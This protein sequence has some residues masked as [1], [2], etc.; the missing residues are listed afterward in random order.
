MSNNYKDAFD[1]F[2]RQEIN[3]TPIAIDTA[4]WMELNNALDFYYKEKVTTTWIGTLRMNWKMI[5]TV[6][7]IIF[8]S[9][10]L[11]VSLVSKRPK[12]V[13][14]KLKQENSFVP[15]G[16]EQSNKNVK[17]KNKSEFQKVLKTE[18]E[19]ILEKE[20]KSKIEVGQLA[21]KVTP[22][23]DLLQQDGLIPDSLHD[24]NS[25]TVKSDTLHSIKKKKKHL[26]W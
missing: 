21:K 20:E 5:L 19:N 22:I 11:S 18:H 6:L 15:K 8:L 1:D 10:T 17:F 13:K 23:L 3:K 9:F 16:E 14:N 25:G 26:L 4:H 2:I 24:S 7:V 12:D